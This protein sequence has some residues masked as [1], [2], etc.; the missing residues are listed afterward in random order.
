MIFNALTSGGGDALALPIVTGQTYPA[1]A[2][3]GTVWVGTTQEITSFYLSA[4]QPETPTEGQ[5]LLVT[6]DTGIQAFFGKKNRAALRLTFASRYTDGAWQPVEALLYRGSTWWPVS[7]P[8]L[9]KEG[10]DGA[11]WTKKQVQGT[12]TAGAAAITVKTNGGG[13]AGE[14]YAVFGPLALSGVSAVALRAKKTDKN[15][16]VYVAILAAKSADATRT[17]AEL[18]NE[19]EIKDNDEHEVTL[20]VSSLSGNGWY[21]Y[22]GINTAGGSWSAARTASV[23]EVRLE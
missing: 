13:K 10:V 15:A 7:D 1:S 23:L 17:T 4:D 5:L 18:K 2:K 6:A 22:A 8:S 12:V 14:A 20:D 19:T 21:L 11:T 9:Y 16:N 3:D